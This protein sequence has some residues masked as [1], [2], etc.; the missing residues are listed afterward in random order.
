[1]YLHLGLFLENYMQT[2][3]SPRMWPNWVIGPKRC[4]MFW[5][6]CKNK[7]P[8]FFNFFHFKIFFFIFWDFWT[9]N[10]DEKFIFAPILFKLFIFLR[11][12]WKV[13]RNLLF[14]IRAKKCLLR[15]WLIFFA[16]VLD[17]S[18]K[19]KLSKKRFEKKNVG[20]KKCQFFFA[21]SR[22]MTLLDW[23]PLANWLSG[24]NGY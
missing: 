7:F 18:K 11:I 5:N 8:L 10:V 1:M 17:D 13:C 14:K 23:I 20:R 19:K 16:Y 15:F 6:V 12:I 9:K 24:I 3:S 2:S 21:R 4:V 22:F